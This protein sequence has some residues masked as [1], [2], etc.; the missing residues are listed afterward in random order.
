M[1]NTCLDTETV[2]K[3]IKMVNESDFS[4]KDKQKYTNFL[5]ERLAY[6]MVIEAWHCALKDAFDETRETGSCDS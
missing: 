6:L 1:T 3:L 5:S 2:V 4:K